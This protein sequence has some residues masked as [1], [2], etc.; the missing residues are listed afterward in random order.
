MLQLVEKI[1]L[2]AVV[3]LRENVVEQNHRLLAHALPEHGGFRQLEREHGAA[4]LSLR[5]IGLGVLA[6]DEDLHIVAVRPRHGDAHVDV[7]RPAARAFFAEPLTDGVQIVLGL[8]VLCRQIADLELLSALGNAAVECRRLFGQ[9][10]HII[11]PLAYQHGAVGDE[12]PVPDVERVLQIGLARNVL[13]QRVAL[14]EHAVVFGEN[15]RVLQLLAADGA[16]DEPPPFAGS[17]LDQIEV[18]RRKRHGAEF[19]YQR[20]CGGFFDAV[21]RHGLFAVQK[22]QHGVLLALLPEEV[23]LQ[24]RKIFA[25][26]NDLAV[27]C[28]AKGMTAAEQPQRFDDIRLSL[29]VVAVDDVYAVTGK[30]LA[31][32]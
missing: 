18:L 29:R 26:L 20:R 1:V 9:H 22:G 11:Q 25:P 23:H 3:Q 28:G 12:L 4:L 32:L 15:D 2:P 5:G 31:I 13:E 27:A 19:F 8:N 14:G 6:V 10:L 16:V 7:A 30:Q 24:P 21:D 17:A